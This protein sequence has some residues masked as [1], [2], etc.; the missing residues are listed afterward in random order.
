MVAS[1]YWSR[2]LFHL[3]MNMSQHQDTAEEDIKF[4]LAFL[5]L[6]DFFLMFAGVFVLNAVWWIRIPFQV[7][8]FFYAI[9]VLR[10]AYVAARYV[11]VSI[12]FQRQIGIFLYLS[13]HSIQFFAFGKMPDLMVAYLIGAGPLGLWFLFDHL[14]DD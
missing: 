5:V 11:P 10:L 12:P 2:T 8:A 14:L 6:A 4:W 9:F 3:N 13:C 1:T 7:A